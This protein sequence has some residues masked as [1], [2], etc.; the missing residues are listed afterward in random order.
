M[1]M[2]SRLCEHDA[3]LCDV[4]DGELGLSSLPCDPADGSGQV[5]SLQRFHCR[6]GN[7]RKQLKHT[8]KPDAEPQS[9]RLTVCDVEAF[10]EELV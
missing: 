6:H 9:L 7:K 3:G 1:E 8:Q 4:F 5:V 10:Q 2:N